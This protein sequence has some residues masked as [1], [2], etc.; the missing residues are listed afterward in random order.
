MN[1]R[2]WL[3]VAVSS[4]VP[5]TVAASASSGTD[6]LLPHIH[7]KRCCRQRTEESEVSWLTQRA[8]FNPHL[9]FCFVTWVPDFLNADRGS[10]HMALQTTGNTFRALMS[11][12]EQKQS[13]SGESI[14]NQYTNNDQSALQ[15]P[16][17]GRHPYF[18]SPLTVSCWFTTTSRSET[19]S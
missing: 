8:L 13:C 14:H 3:T 15:S 11:E 9:A 4:S 5:D 2:S 7:C 18:Y 17:T 6:M 16:L 1:K 19:A 12:D 10:T